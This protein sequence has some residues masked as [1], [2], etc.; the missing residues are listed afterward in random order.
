[1]KDAFVA[2][3]SDVG[4]LRACSWTSELMVRLFLALGLLALT[5]VA[6]AA[7]SWVRIPE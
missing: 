3:G 6:A 7:Q 2:P 5:T 1:M 4:R